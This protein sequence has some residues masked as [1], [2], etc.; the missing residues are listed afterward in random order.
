[1]RSHAADDL[2]APAGWTQEAVD[3]HR[4]GV[5]PH[6]IAVGTARS[7]IV[8]TTLLFHSAAPP[9]SLQDAEHV[10]EAGIDLPNSDLAIYG[11][12]DDP[13]Q[14]RHIS[15]TAG[16]YRVRVSY[17]P[18][19]LPAAGFDD[20]EYGD[21]FRYQLDLWPADE[22]APLAVLKQGPNPWAT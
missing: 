13:G 11:P 8:E 15:V 14:E 5:Q 17:I 4:I 9:M 22:R 3:L 6:S 10:V 16:H 20:S 21:H 19:D 7:D 12:A 18:S 1:M 2:H